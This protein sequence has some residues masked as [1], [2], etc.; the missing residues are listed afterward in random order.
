MSVSAVEI[1]MAVQTLILLATGGVVAWYTVE[2]KRIR[3][4]AAKQASVAQEQT[5]LLARQLDLLLEERAAQTKLVTTELQARAT[6]F[7]N[8]LLDLP[9]GKDRAKADR[10]FR[11][12][13]IW[14]AEDVRRLLQAATRHSVEAARESVRL[15][16]DLEYMWGR[17]HEV[18]STSVQQGYD[19][20]RFDWDHWDKRL[21]SA[22]AHAYQLK[23]TT[24]KWEQHE[25]DF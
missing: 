15:A 10:Q 17:I 21:L 7:H 3:E 1:M 25:G 6:Q 8:T 18:R 23:M 22:I 16:P 4:A 13:P 9:N 24:E 5:N 19:W 11:T 2:T 14:D 12:A 20:S